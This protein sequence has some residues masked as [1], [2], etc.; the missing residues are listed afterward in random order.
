MP[1]I[2]VIRFSSIG[3]IVL[4]SPV[5]RCIKKQL[6]D[7]EVHFL[8]KKQFAPIVASSPYIDKVIEFDNN[9]SD[10]KEQLA[11]ENYDHI[12][13]LHHNLRSSLIKKAL[14]T[15]ATSFNKLN[16]E[17][18]LLVNLKINKL[19][20]VHI[21]ERYFE[22]VRGLGV[23][24]D[25]E[26]LDYF[27]GDNGTLTESVLTKIGSEKFGVVVAGANHSTKKMPSS[28]M[29]TV[30]K[31]IHHRV[32]VL[33]GPDDIPYGDEICENN[34]NSINLCGQLTLAQ[35]A[36][37][38]KHS[39]VVITP[40]TGLMHIAAAFKKPV[41]SIWGN[42]VPEFGMYPYMPGQENNSVIF[43][44]KGLKCRPCSK[45]GYEKC[46]KGHFKCMNEQDII[47]ISNTANNI[48]R[49]VQ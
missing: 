25:K 46:P 26:G 43:E 7:A 33:G 21:V 5:T 30:I 2:L 48:L 24:N 8:T 34:A 3:D 31:D 40:D 28:L 22:T 36:Q 16:F 20:A 32:I 10:V 11:K 6:H 23:S 9:L 18:W 35:S 27:I 1:K 15:Q 12:V 49:S 4:T 42:T 47:K 44:V 14:K 41:L 13:D 29:N 19:P 38:V 45:I 39:V 17:K 37:V